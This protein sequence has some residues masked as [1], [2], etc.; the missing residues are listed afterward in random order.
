MKPWFTY[1][2]EYDAAAW[3]P[4]KS[5]Q[6]EAHA[7]HFIVTAML[8]IATG[9][10]AGSLFV[11]QPFLSIFLVL[12]ASFAYLYFQKL[13]RRIQKISDTES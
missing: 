9:V 4:F 6:F 13:Q 12:L 3:F 11:T 2:E 7:L 10:I 8:G 1:S 5:G